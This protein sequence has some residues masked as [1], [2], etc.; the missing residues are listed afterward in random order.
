MEVVYERCCGMDV[1]KD[2]IV[3]CVIVN[4]KEVRSFETVTESLIEMV[5]WLKEED[6]QAVAM[7]STGSYWKPI[8]NLLELEE[9][10][11][12]VVNAQHIKAVPGR[13]TDVKD[14]EWIADLLKHG[15]LKGSYIPN[16]EQRELKELVRY[17]RSLIDERSR[18]LN[19]LQKILE[20]ANIKLSSVVSDIDGVSSRMTLESLIKGVVDVNVMAA[21][22]KGKM[23]QKTEELKKALTG[24]VGSHQRMI[25]AEMLK[26]IDSLKESIQRLDAEVKERMRPFEVEVASLDSIV[27]VGERSAQTIIAEIGTDMSVFATAGHLASWAGMCPGNNESAGKKKSGKTRKGSKSLRSTLVECAKAA[28]RSKSSYLSAQYKRISSRRGRNRADIA[29]GH[30]ILEIAYHILKDKTTYKDM[31]ADYFDKRRKQDLVRR[32]VK[33]LEAMGLVVTVSEKEP[34]A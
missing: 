10:K 14:S 25:L 28:G 18:E 4:N 3:A 30:T 1:H 7:E 5:D 8:Y 26:H 9:V 24:M 33:R 16:R 13:K 20:G 21:L 19:R 11:T 15:L 23:K 6:C 2:K 22:A 17:R 32:S 34:A 31:G 29:V 12:M 27:G